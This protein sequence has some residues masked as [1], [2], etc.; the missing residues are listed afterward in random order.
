VPQNGGADPPKEIAYPEDASKE[1]FKEIVRIWNDARKKRYLCAHG[2]DGINGCIGNGKCG[3]DWFQTGNSTY[4]YQ[5]RSWEVSSYTPKDELYVFSSTP[6]GE[7]IIPVMLA[8]GY[9]PMVLT[10]RTLAG[11]VA[12]FRHPMYGTTYQE[13]ARQIEEII[14]ANWWAGWGTKLRTNDYIYSQIT[15][16][17]T[18]TRYMGSWFTTSPNGECDLIGTSGLSKTAYFAD[19]NGPQWYSIGRYFGDSTIQNECKYVCPYGEPLEYTRVYRYKKTVCG[20]LE[21]D[22][23]YNKNPGYILNC[24]LDKT[25]SSIK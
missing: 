8:V 13:A 14:G 4:N 21:Y 5:T 12:S 23:E 3:T 19:M 17:T 1:P 10:R 11:F 9:L 22:T 18:K 24:G 7:T 15:K 2:N 25:T 16:Y 20:E 6:A